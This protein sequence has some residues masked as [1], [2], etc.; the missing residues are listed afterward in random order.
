M[1]FLLTSVILYF[2]LCLSLLAD[3]T[4]VEIAS[5][6]GHPPI[7]KSFTTTVHIDVDS[8]P[9]GGY[10]FFLNYNPTV[11]E[12]VDIKGGLTPEFAHKPL[13]D[14]RF[15]AQGSFRFGA[16]QGMSFTAPMGNIEIAKITFRVKGNPRSTTSLNLSSNMA[17]NVD[18]VAYNTKVV[19]GTVSIGNYL[20]DVNTDD[21]PNTIADAVYYINNL[22]GTQE[23]ND[24]ELDA[25]DV[26]QDEI[27]ATIADVVFMINIM[28]GGTP[29]PLAGILETNIFREFATLQTVGGS[30]EIRIPPLK[31]DENGRGLLPVALKS[32]INIGGIYLQFKY[33]AEKLSLNEPSLSEF[34]R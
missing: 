17:I 11:L 31:F 23:L 27:P 10:D 1:R 12:I 16:L 18:R 22:M 29:S 3:S 20:G 24:F 21:E 13:H 26:N 34:G 32:D 25:S 6:T 14:S 2:S 4:H 7:G 30:V 28:L 5:P 19:D 9:L 33:N 15:V 8:T